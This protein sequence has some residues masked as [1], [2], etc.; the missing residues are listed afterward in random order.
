MSE[1]W[2]R[3]GKDSRGMHWKSWESLC[4]PEAYGGL[5][6]KD[7]EAYNLALLGKDT[8]VWQERWIRAAPATMIQSMRRGEAQ[9]MGVISEDMR[10]SELI[11]ANGRDW[12]HDKIN[13]LFTEEVQDK[14]LSIRPAGTS[15]KDTYVW[16]YTKTGHTVKSGYWV[17]TSILSSTTEPQEVIQPSLDCIYQMVW[18]LE[19]SPKIKHFLWRCLNNS[20]PVAENMTYR[21]I[22]KDKRCSRCDG[23]AE[24]VNHLLFQCHYA[25]RAWAVANIHIPPSGKWSDSLFDNLYWVLNLKQEYQ[26]E[27]VD[28]GFVPVLLWRLW[29]NRNEFLFRGKDYDADSTVR[30]VWEDVEEWRNREDV[31]NEEVKTPTTAVSDRKWNPPPP[32]SVKCNTDGS[33]SKETESGGVGWVLRDP[34]RT[35]VWAGAR[36]LPVVRS[37]IEVEAEAISAFHYYSASNTHLGRYDFDKS[38][39]DSLQISRNIKAL[40]F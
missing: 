32:L 31:K 39:V 35:L 6:F 13:R 22:A 28:E 36:K 33:W 23:E 3:N 18:R 29:K 38:V 37:A 2:W 14:I 17:Q 4:R 5:G 19:T 7:L 10:V 9:E 30:K 1:F 21:H 16:T 27:E 11:S 12:N 8:K 25:R 40:I 26:K 34:Q 15:S 20:L 24:S